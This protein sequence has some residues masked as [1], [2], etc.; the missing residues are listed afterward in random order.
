M[1]DV[2][3]ARYKGVSVGENCRILTR[4]FGSEP[5][6]IKIGNKVTIAP[7]VQFITHDGSTWLFSDEKGRR[8]LF[9]KVE[10]GSNVFVGM[11]SILMPGVKIEDNVIV[12]AG[13]VLVKSVPSG[14]IVGGNPAKIIGD[15]FNYKKNV[16]E[17]Y[18]S[19]S[20]IDFNEDYK[21]RTVKAVDKS[22][23]DY[24]KK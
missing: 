3:Y 22:Y 1:S 16:L 11:D 20:E 24:M 13:S 23:K 19:N 14:V 21:I 15:Y 18:I 17:N 6:L 2:E 10:I 5:W 4:S 8:Q 12:A 7:K 9:R